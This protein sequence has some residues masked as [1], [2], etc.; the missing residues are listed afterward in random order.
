MWPHW[1]YSVAVSLSG[2]LLIIL[3]LTLLNGFFSAAEIGVLAVR[4]TRLMELVEEGRRGARA[5]L[6]LRDDPED[7]LATVQV[8]ITF[9]SASAGAFGG[10]TL[11][12]P[13][14][15]RLRSLGIERGAEQ[16]AF[17]LVVSLISTLSIVLGELVPKS[18]ALRSS[19]RVSLWVARPLKALARAARPLIWLLTSLS[20]LLL[21]P[22]RDQTNFI[23]ARI[24]PDE[25]QTMVE[26]ASTAGALSPGI[27]AITSRA[28]DLEQ[29]P[30]SSLLIPRRDVVSIPLHASRDE[31]WQILKRSPHARYPVVERTLDAVEGY[32]TTRDLVHQ[33]VETHAVDVR[34]VLRELPAFAERAPAVEVLRAL[35]EKR[36]QLGLVVDEHGMVSGIICIADIVEELLGEILDEHER[37]VR[38]LR[39]EGP[40][41]ALVRADTPIQEV[42]R[43]LNLDLPLSADYATLSGLLMERSTRIMKVG[44]RLELA[45]ISFEVVEATPR[46]VK[47][48]RVRYPQ[49]S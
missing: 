1:A 5:A 26:E 27:G 23:E 10:V 46:L 41:V 29:L 19:E 8:G 33:I 4:R 39:R 45:D 11:A 3:A 42:N 36:N 47:L 37:P 34:A 25:L 15:D 21:R 38:S 30:I 18:L 31:V 48:I 22:L 35:Q 12:A 28:L 44:E 6:S 14:A 24:S 2:E 17:V 40:G 20:N 43:E 7:F 49:S 9:I 32:V 13:L 16:L